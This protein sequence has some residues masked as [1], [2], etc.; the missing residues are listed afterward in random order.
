MICCWLLY[1]TYYNR[2]TQH[3]DEANED[4]ELDSEDSPELNNSHKQRSDTLIH[5]LQALY[6][7]TAKTK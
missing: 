3:E 2:V 4:L 1:P 5:E 6:S 7:H